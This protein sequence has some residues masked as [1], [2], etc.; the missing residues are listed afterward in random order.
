[1]RPLVLGAIAAVAEGF[2]AAAV[3]AGVGPLAGM[4][5]LVDLEVLQ[6]REGLFAAGELEK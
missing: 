3:L 2:R 6:A 5:P 4:R 1:M